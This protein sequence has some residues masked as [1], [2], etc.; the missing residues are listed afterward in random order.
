[1]ATGHLAAGGRDEFHFRNASAAVFAFTLL[2]GTACAAADIGGVANASGD[3]NVN[4]SSPNVVPNAAGQTGVP[5][6]KSVTGANADVGTSTM[7]KSEAELPNNDAGTPIN[8]GPTGKV[9]QPRALVPH[10]P[11]QQ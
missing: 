6:T 7:G 11:R 3:A 10:Q 5:G 1:M 9:G 8:S 2:T 4:S